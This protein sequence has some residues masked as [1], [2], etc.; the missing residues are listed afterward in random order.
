MKTPTQTHAGIR[1]SMA[2]LAC[3]VGMIAP[4]LYSQTVAT[5]SNVAAAAGSSAAITMNPFEVTEQK[6]NSFVT[7]SVGTGGRLVLDL[8]DV[9]AAY[10]SINRAM[11]EALGI[12]DI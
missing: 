1:R 6:D 7:N 11:I 8:K 4:G 9:P 5:P 3:A 10:Y 12:T 2:V